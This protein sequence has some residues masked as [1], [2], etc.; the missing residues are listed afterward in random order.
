MTDNQTKDAIGVVNDYRQLIAAQ[1]TLLLS[2]CSIDNEPDISYAPFVRNE[3]G[4]FYI[5]ISTLAKH[6]KHLMDNPLASIL[7]IEPE[8]RCRN[9]FARARVVFQCSVIHIEPGT[10]AYEN[11]LR[12]LQEKFGETVALLRTL[13]DFHLF[14]LKPESGHYVAGFGKAYTINLNDNSLSLIGG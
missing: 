13:P 11:Q 7:F 2:T 8:E 12:A 5:F 4:Y 3:Q 14:Q 1:Q 9:L 6:T 10:P